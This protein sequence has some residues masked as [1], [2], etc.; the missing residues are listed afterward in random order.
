MTPLPS[1]P[2]GQ[3]ALKLEKNTFFQQNQFL[4]RE[5]SIYPHFLFHILKEEYLGVTFRKKKL[6]GI[7]GGKFST[8]IFKKKFK[9]RHF[10]FDIY[11]F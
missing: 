11:Q 10:F 2:G 8:G 6:W 4:E 9:N 7:P 1:L 3:K 5:R